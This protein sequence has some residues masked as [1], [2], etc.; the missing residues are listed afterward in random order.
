MSP[1]PSTTQFNIIIPIRPSIF[2]WKQ[3]KHTLS[4]K[5]LDRKVIHQK[6]C[7]NINCIYYTYLC[8][9]TTLDN[10]EHKKWKNQFILFHSKHQNTH[11]HHIHNL[12]IYYTKLQKNHFKKLIT[13]HFDSRNLKISNLFH[14]YFIYHSSLSSPKNAIQRKISKRTLMLYK[15]KIILLHYM[16]ILDYTLGKI[17]MAMDPIPKQH[18][19]MSF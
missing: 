16:T 11:E 14:L 2:T 15:Y 5:I 9:Y 4:N 8:K 12:T 17:T 10:I 19:I 6:I 18:V 7:F 3:I 13:N 1:T